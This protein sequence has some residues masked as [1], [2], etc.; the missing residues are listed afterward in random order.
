MNQELIV[1]DNKEVSIKR[2]K[3][4][5]TYDGLLEGLPT[6]RMYFRTFIFIASVFTTLTSSG[7]DTTCISKNLGKVQ[8]KK[9]S[10]KLTVT[11]K[12]KL[13]SMVKI[14]NG[15]TI[16]DLL[17]V[18][19]YPDLCDACGAL[20]WDRQ[21]SVIHYLIKKGVAEKRLRF[22]NYF[23]GNTDFIELTFTSKHSTKEP[24]SHPNLKR[25]KL[26]D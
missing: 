13:D 25:E 4:W 21:K 18:N 3:Q 16:C 20:A 19:H 26:S 15:Q 5:L 7:Q 14:I 6:T 10:A 23:E 2:I 24:R 17:L 1:E 8:F 9:N 11:A 12:S 22:V